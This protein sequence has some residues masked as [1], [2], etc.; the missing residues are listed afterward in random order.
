MTIKEHLNVLDHIYRVYDAFIKDYDL[1]CQKGCGRCCTRNVTLTTL[2]AYKITA[3][4]DR[5]EQE[6][7][8]RKMTAALD[9]PRFIPRLSTN[10]L[11]A[12]CLRGEDPPEEEND[13]DWGACPVLNDGVCPMYAVRPFGCRCMVSSIRCD[14]AGFAEMDPF[15]VTVNNVMMQYIEHVDRQGYSGNLADLVLFMRSDENRRRYR[16]GLIVETPAGMIPNHPIQAL[17]VPP[18]HRQR[19]SSLI[20]ALGQVPGMS[21]SP[22]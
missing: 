3:C 13:P 22:E 10:A 14:E 8:F 6:D 5:K 18:R 21:P 7:H 4:L 9:R 17:M 16:E 2:E 15:I 11:A 20:K 1:S 19:I 12:L